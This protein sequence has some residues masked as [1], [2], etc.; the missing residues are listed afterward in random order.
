MPP[1]PLAVDTDVFSFVRNR[2]GRYAEWERFLDGRRLAYPF[3]V[4]GELL[5]GEYKVKAGQ[6]RRDA[7]LRR[8]ALGTVIPSDARVVEIWAQLHGRF[9]GRLKGE[10]INDM[11]I[12]ACCLVHALPLATGNLSDYGTIAAEFPLNVVHPDL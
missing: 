5:G 1:G 2:R 7:L 10:G 9:H 3:P 4:V 8:I 6:P 11:W 12:A